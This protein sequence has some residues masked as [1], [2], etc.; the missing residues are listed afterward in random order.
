MR[1]ND[2]AGNQKRQKDASGD[3]DCLAGDRSTLLDR[4]SQ[5]ERHEQRDRADRI[6]RDQQHQEIASDLPQH[7]GKLPD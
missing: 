2:L 7:G 5:R 6:D 1:E 4:E 3:Q